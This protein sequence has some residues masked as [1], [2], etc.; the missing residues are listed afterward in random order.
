MTERDTNNKIDGLTGIL[1]AL[2][3]ALGLSV[4]FPAWQKHHDS[5][6][7]LELENEQLKKTLEL[8]RRYL[9][10]YKDGNT[11]D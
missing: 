5:V 11:E 1:F 10:G 9:E 4:L 2:V 6:K 7:Q 3:V 8:E